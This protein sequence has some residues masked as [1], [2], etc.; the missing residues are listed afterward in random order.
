MKSEDALA[1]AALRALL[2]RMEPKLDAALKEFG[3]ASPEEL[4]PETKSRV[5][6]EAMLRTTV[7]TFPGAQLDAMKHALE[8]FQHPRFGAAFSRLE[9]HISGGFDAFAPCQGI[10]AAVVLGGF[11]LPV[12]PFDRKD[13]KITEQ[14]TNRIDEISKSFS[15]LKTAYVGYSVCDLPFYIMVTDCIASA[16]SLIESHPRFG[17]VRELLRRD[18]VN[19]PRGSIRPFQHALLLFPRHPGDT[20]SSVGHLDPLPS[21]GSVTLYAGWTVAGERYGCAHDGYA[22]VPLQFLS[23]AMQD[24][25]TAMWIWRPVGPRILMN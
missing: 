2:D 14:P 1:S 25:Q 8:A 7:E 24:T 12:A 4:P 13:L 22:P 20:I 19:M 10:A 16:R 9:R 17:E 5:F 3:V 15:K 23:T 21:R 18:S 6:Q 11:G